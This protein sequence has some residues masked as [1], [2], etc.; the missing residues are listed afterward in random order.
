MVRV[1][2]AP[3][4]TGELHLGGARTALY[5]Y[6]FT[7]KQGGDFIVR[8]EDTDQERFVPGSLDRILNGLKWLGLVWTE[9][10]DIGGPHGP[11]VQSER[12]ALH[13]QYA[14]ELVA[15]GH[16]YHCFCSSQRLEELRKSQEAQKLPT[17]Y[18][19]H[20][21]KLNEGEVTAKLAKGESSIIRLK[22][23]EGDTTFTDL[24]HGPMRVSNN[25]LDDQVLLKSDG[26]PTYHLANVVDDHLMDITHVIRGEEW[27]PSAPKHIILYQA[28]GWV[29]PQFAHLPNV[30]NEQRAKL[31]K[32]RDGETV[33]VET[34]Q[35]RGYLPQAF[36]NFLVLMGWHPTSDRE[37]FTLEEL[38]QEF[39]LKRVQKGGAIFSP[40]KLDWL[41]TQYIKKL[42]I[43]TLDALLQPYYRQ[44]AEQ[45]GR[46][47]ADTN[48]LSEVLRSRLVTL[49]ETLTQAGWYFKPEL[50]LTPE[51]LTPSNGQPDKTAQALRAASEAMEKVEEWDTNGIKNSLQAVVDQGQFSRAELLWPVRVALTGERQS[52]DVYEIAWALGRD[53]SLKRLAAASKIMPT[54]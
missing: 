31:S 5:N 32:R 48:H 21:L 50:Q 20:C 54:K 4:P 46:K 16:A 3:S 38:V 18:D 53:E 10:P 49:A 11:Y 12:S 41:N 52:P 30:L 22:I 43:K 13:Q 25:T 47:S 37:L 51:L 44:L 19:R 2:F 33:W 17:R 45:G 27:L 26:F 42:D 29:P 40:K 9:G 24:I 8:L 1:R 39:D 35:R 34:Y 36:V 28:L 23:P 15:K 14:R 6:L 7:K